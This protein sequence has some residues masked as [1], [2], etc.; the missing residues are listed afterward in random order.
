MGFETFP[1]SPLWEA[2]VISSYFLLVCRHLLRRHVE[3]DRP[4]VDLFVGVH[5]GHDEEETGAFGAAGS[6]TT[7]SEHYCPLVLLN[8]LQ[9]W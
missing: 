8:H 7:K 9:I 2:P 4:Q 3:G 6:Q 5:T 1:R